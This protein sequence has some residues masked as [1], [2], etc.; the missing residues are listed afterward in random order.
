MGSLGQDDEPWTIVK[1]ATMDHSTACLNE[2]EQ[3]LETAHS[4]PGKF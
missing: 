2:L 4:P 1:L 3:I